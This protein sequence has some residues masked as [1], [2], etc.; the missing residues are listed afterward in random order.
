VPESDKILVFIPTYNE[1]ENVESLFRQI[2][3]LGISLDILFLDDNSPDGTGR[4]ID[5][6]I[7]END[8]VF[9]I[10]R[11]GKLGIGSA[12]RTGITWAYQNG[13]KILLTMDCDFTHSPKYIPSFIELASQADI[14]VGSRYLNRGSLDDW[15][16]F[17]KILTRFAHFLTVSLLLLPH[18]AS[19]AYR[20]YNI[21][22]IPSEIFNRVQSNSY[23][24][25]FESLHILVLNG[26]SVMEFSIDLPSR[27]CGHSKMSIKDMAV[28]ISFLIR[29]FINSRF[30]RAS[31][32]CDRNL[33][34]F[35]HDD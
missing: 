17:R 19:G 31:L 6:I 8:G 15:N 14:V 2:R 33:A 27:T 26:C 24:F 21:D 25:F 18:D 20:L 28:S 5:R 10:H 4:M 7:A 22:R 29:L 1:A 16:M 35:K 9:V 3:D 34:T 30:D 13:Y 23:S 11:G 32:L 12:H